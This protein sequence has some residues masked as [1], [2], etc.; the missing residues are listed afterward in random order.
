MEEMFH[1]A[2]LKKKITNRLTDRRD[3]MAEVYTKTCPQCGREYTTEQSRKKI[4]PE[5]LNKNDKK[6][7]NAV[8]A[9]RMKPAPKKKKP[10]KTFPTLYEVSRVERIYNAVKKTHKHYHDIVHIIESSKAE[11][12]VCCGATIPEGRMVCPACERKAEEAR[13]W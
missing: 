12:C 13:R 7:K 1:K 6:R 11:C 8:R 5:C 3:N 10:K 2:H 4:C 9:V